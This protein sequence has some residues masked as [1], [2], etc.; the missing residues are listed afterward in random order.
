MYT[1]TLSALL[2]FAS[3]LI[4]SYILPLVNNFFTV[5]YCFFETF[6]ST[7][8]YRFSALFQLSCKV[9]S[10]ASA[11]APASQLGKQIPIKI[12]LWE[13]LLSEYRQ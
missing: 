6:F 9:P 8:F 10:R 7:I 11:P 4:V 13:C 12:L 3:F 1:G 5:F 2:T